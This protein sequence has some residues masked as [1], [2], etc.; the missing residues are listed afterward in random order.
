MNITDLPVSN[1]VK[2][3]L[4]EHFDSVESLV[5]VVKHREERSYYDGSGTYM[6]GG[7]YWPLARIPAFGTKSAMETAAAL[8][9]TGLVTWDDCN[10]D[11]IL[12]G[13]LAREH[14]NRKA[15][16]LGWKGP[17]LPGKI[18][19][20]KLTKEQQRRGELIARRE[21]LVAQVA[22]IDAELGAAKPSQ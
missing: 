4:D 21:R 13:L 12:H 8:L 18:E 22:V 17:F 2:R 19:R 20:R 15:R 1:R 5:A 6:H 16:E 7:A 10:L 3:L 14:F 11:S 9:A